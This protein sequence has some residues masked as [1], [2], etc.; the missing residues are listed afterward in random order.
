[1]LL[2]GVELIYDYKPYKLWGPTNK[3][4]KE[5]DLGPLGIVLRRKL[6]DG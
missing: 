2:G 4:H 3:I 1:M 5:D 6:R